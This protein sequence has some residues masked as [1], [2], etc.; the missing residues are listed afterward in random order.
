MTD[1]TF[2]FLDIQKLEPPF[3]YIL[4]IML[5]RQTTAKSTCYLYISSIEN[6][7]VVGAL[8][9]YPFIPGEFCFTATG[10]DI[11]GCPIAEA[12]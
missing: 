6:L 1:L 12:C 11:K 2:E 8:F 10:S 5:Y 3:S 9:L 4:E 7:H